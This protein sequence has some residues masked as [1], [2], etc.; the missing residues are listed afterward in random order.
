MSKAN[1]GIDFQSSLFDCSKDFCPGLD[2]S[3]VATEPG[4]ELMLCAFCKKDALSI[5]LD[6]YPEL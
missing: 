2:S 5:L 6:I 1:L 3:E 4:I